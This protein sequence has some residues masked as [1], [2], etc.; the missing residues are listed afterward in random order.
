M[1]KSRLVQPGLSPSKRMN[2]DPFEMG[3]G[4]S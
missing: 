3:S 1:R 2:M 4:V